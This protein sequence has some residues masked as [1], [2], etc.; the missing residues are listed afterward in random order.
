[1]D[2]GTHFKVITDM[3]VIARAKGGNGP[4]APQRIPRPVTLC[5]RLRRM[6]LRPTAY[7]VG[8]QMKR[9]SSSKSAVL[10]H[11]HE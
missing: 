4:L 7:T 9:Y 8:A 6:R 3:A 10:D 5:A 1:M 11:L 2:F